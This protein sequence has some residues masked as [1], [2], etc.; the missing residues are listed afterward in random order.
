MGRKPEAKLGP[1]GQKSH[2][3]RRCKLGKPPKEGEACDH[4]EACSVH[5]AGVEGK[6]LSLSG[7]I[8]RGVMNIMTSQIERGGTPRQK[9]ADVIVPT[10]R[11]WEGLNVNNGEIV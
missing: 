7:E 11:R 2:K 5:A 10:T 3:K 6:L 1:D 8:C 9:S 4:Q